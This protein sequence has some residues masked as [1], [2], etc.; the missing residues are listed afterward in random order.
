MLYDAFHAGKVIDEIP[1]KFD[2]IQYR[3][4]NI[5]LINPDDPINLDLMITIHIT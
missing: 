2:L 3:N 4:Q 1:P 5:S